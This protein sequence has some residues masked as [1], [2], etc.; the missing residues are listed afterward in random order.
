MW[1]LTSARRMRS[2]LIELLAHELAPSEGRAQAVLRIAAAC[3]ITVAI[4]MVFQIPEPTYMAYIVFLV[5]KDESS[6]TVTTGIGALL[7]ATLGIVLNLGLLIV[8]IGEP[9][10]R[11][12][13]M[14]LA[15]F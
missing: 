1:T 8:D 15:T 12:P 11:L 2:P 10:L 13:A 6:A 9:A 7:A 3:S 4:A 14:A 5:S